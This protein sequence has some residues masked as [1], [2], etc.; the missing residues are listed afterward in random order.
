MGHSYSANL[1]GKFFAGNHLSHIQPESAVPL[2]YEIANNPKYDYS[3]ILQALQNINSDESVD[4]L[5]KLAYSSNAELRVQA[6]LH[7]GQTHNSNV[8][9]LV[10][11]LLEHNDSNVRSCAV[12][13]LD[14]LAAFDLERVINA[15]LKILES[16]DLE[17][18]ESA[19][20]SLSDVAKNNRDAEEEY[21][22]IID[23]LLEALNHPSDS[24]M[25]R[26]AAS[27]LRH[28][29]FPAVITGLEKS[30]R[31][32]TSY[33]VRAIAADSLGE[34]GCISSI[35]YLAEALENNNRFVR[36]RVAFALGKIEDPSVIPVLFRAF[37]H[38][39][40]NV[41]EKAAWALGKRG[42]KEV[43]PFLSEKL[44]YSTNDRV[45]L[46]A[47]QSII[48][49][50]DKA[51]LPTLN[52]ALEDAK[53]DVR[54]NVVLALSNIKEEKAISLLLKAFADPRQSVRKEA[55][56]VLKKELGPEYLDDVKRIFLEPMYFIQT[57]N[58]QNW[59]IKELQKRERYSSELSNSLTN[60]LVDIQEKAIEIFLSIQQRCQYYDYNVWYKAKR[61][62][63]YF[64]ELWLRN[65]EV[66]LENM[67]TF[68]LK[69]NKQVLSRTCR[70]IS[71]F[72]RER[73][74]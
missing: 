74:F 29:N 5:Y 41:R 23:K 20:Y 7:L 58:N 39:D 6:T 13:V 49:V 14:S 61:H 2:L 21:S 42:F 4:A 17:M 27:T 38:E 28:H 71:H 57:S 59:E 11:K 43:I 65:R 63:C 12:D 67:A 26:N 47:A 70:F 33:R 15:L 68:S 22:L 45:R 37:E 3:S 9:P 35:S 36:D 8:V 64:R 10:L 54:K 72:F 69:K 60:N 48:G 66:I 56:N 50:S 30:L 32:D 19:V 25:R 51:I 44:K 24:S 34:L 46:W 53:V 55:A 31:E 1:N 40:H 62:N 16:S 18:R 73:D 52:K